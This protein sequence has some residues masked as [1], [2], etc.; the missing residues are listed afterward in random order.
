LAVRFDELSPVVAGTHRRER[1]ICDV[2]RDPVSGFSSIHN[3]EGKV[4]VIV[5]KRTRIGQL[6]GVMAGVSV[7]L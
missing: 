4:S 2:R 5:L 7:F 6:L 1:L 3:V